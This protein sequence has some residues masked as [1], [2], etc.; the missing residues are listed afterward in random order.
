MGDTDLVTAEP[1]TALGY[2]NM[3]QVSSCDLQLIPRN[4]RHILEANADNLGSRDL[5]DVLKSLFIPV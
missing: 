4:L 1:S 3:G 5:L 2:G